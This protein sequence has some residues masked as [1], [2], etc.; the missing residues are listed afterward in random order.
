MNVVMV[1]TIYQI[2]GTFTCLRILLREFRK[3]RRHTRP[4]AGEY[5]LVRK[6]DKKVD[7]RCQ[8]ADG[9]GMKET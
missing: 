6:E 1:P 5:Q 7:V 3:L 4:L 9:D 8:L 2:S